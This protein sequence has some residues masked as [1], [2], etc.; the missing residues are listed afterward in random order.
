MVQ[1][2]ALIQVIQQRGALESTSHLTAHFDGDLIH[3]R[4]AG[5]T[6]ITNPGTDND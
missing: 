3:S 1:K 6:A 2:E 5:I 4:E